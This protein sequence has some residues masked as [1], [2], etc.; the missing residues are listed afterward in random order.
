M[1]EQWRLVLCVLYCMVMVAE[2]CWARE[3]AYM[4]A[5]SQRSYCRI[6]RRGRTGQIYNTGRSKR[7]ERLNR[8]C[9]VGLR[10]PI[11]TWKPLG[12]IAWRIFREIRSWLLLLQEPASNGHLRGMNL[13]TILSPSNSIPIGVAVAAHI[14]Q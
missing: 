3:L 6:A 12:S 8:L 10:R 1:E 11:P 7:P 2:W 14:D 9:A 5:R 4:G 13:S